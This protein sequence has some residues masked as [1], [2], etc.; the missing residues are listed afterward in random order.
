MRGFFGRLFGSD[1]PRSTHEEEAEGSEIRLG[2][3]EAKVRSLQVEVADLQAQQID[4]SARLRNAADQLKRAGERYRKLRTP[5]GPR[6]DDGDAGDDWQSAYYALR[7]RGA[8]P[9][10]SGEV[11]DDDDVDEDG[12]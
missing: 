7:G 1:K 9:A 6:A 8:R 11:V 12:E 5:N 3:L 4:Y 2:R 10:P